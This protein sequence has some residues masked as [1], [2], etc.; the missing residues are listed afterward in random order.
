[1]AQCFALMGWSLPVIESMQKLNKPFVVVSFPDFENYAKE[2]DIP[3]VPYQLNEWS[4]SSNSLDLAE[5][6]S[7]FNA[8]VAVPLFEE[9]VEWAGALNS[10][11]RNDPRVLNRAFLFRNKAMM[12]RKALIGGLRVGL[13]EEVYNR[14]GVKSFMHRLNEANLQLHGEEDSWVHIKPFASAGTV[15]HRLLR[16]MSDIDEKVEDED[17]PCLA[18]SHL[19]GQEF[20]CEAFVHGGKVRFLNITEYVRLGYSNFI[21]EGNYLNSKRDRILGEVQK[22]VDIFGIEYGMVHPEWFLTNKDEISFGETACRIPGG[23]ILELAA[24]AYDFDA[25]AAFV[26]CHDPSLTEEELQEILPPMDAR[27]Q[28]FYG[29]VMIYPHKNSISKLEIPEELKEEP[30]FLDHNL[31]PPMTTQKISDRAGFGNHF[32]TVNFKGE[33]PD[34]MRELLLHYENVDF[35]L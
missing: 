31:V 24:K 12:K 8:D 1:M 33:D 3:F 22:L 27:P 15:G 19:S 18:E 28:T 23:H 2:N 16:S 17:F 30:Y 11:Y 9:T 20:S 7:P 4:D 26:L 34:R 6:L 35:Y 14:E 5:K 10:I 21:P 29:N 25:L 13:F 32:G